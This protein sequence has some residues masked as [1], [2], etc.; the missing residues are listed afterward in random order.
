MTLQT[1]LLWGYS[2]VQLT[3]SLHLSVW[4][5][6]EQSAA[7][8]AWRAE[9]VCLSASEARRLQPTVRTEKP[10]TESDYLLCLCFHFGKH[11]SASNILPQHNFIYME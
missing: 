5:N 10:N 1:C 9:D 4:I 6:D 7:D 3:V 8:W 11:I 2:V